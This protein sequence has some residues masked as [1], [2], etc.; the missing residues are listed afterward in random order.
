MK[1][2]PSAVAG[3]IAAA[4]RELRP[5]ELVGLYEGQREALDAELSVVKA[6]A[7]LL[8]GQLRDAQNQLMLKDR[9]AAAAKGRQVSISS[10][11]G[12]V[13]GSRSKWVLQ[14]W[15]KELLCS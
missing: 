9:S 15:E 4:T 8:A 7:K 13:C 10:G 6:E 11:E 2:S 5:I 1:P 3:G 12:D 14:V